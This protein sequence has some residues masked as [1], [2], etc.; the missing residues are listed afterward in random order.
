MLRDGCD[1]AMRLTALSLTAANII[2]VF[3]TFDVP[4]L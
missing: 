1:L 3:I 4:E 2:T